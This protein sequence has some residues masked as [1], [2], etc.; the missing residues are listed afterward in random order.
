MDVAISPYWIIP[1][2]LLYFYLTDTYAN[3]KSSKKYPIAGGLSVLVPRVVQN[4]IFT[5]KAS[6]LCRKS[7]QKFK[8]HAVQFIRTD[9]N[10]VVLPY[11]VLDELS[12]LP[13]THAGPS[14][15][16]ENEL[17]GKYTSISLI[18]D[19]RL[20]FS[21]V[22]RRLTPKIPALAPILEKAATAAFTKYF[23]KAEDWT[24]ITPFDVF[25]EVAARVNATALVGPAFC[26]DPKWL[27]IG[28]K[29]TEH[30]ME[31]MIMLRMVPRLIQPTVAL[32]L[33]SY[34]KGRRCVKQA[35]ELLS[36]KIEEL[37]KANDSG[38]WDPMNSKEDADT[39]VM[40]WLAG[41]VKGNERTP[42]SV[43]HVQILLAF[44]SIH[45]TL[46]RLTNALYDIMAA[47]PSLLAELRAE[48]ESV[49]VDAKGWHD[50]PY[51]RLYKLD[52]LLRES[53]RTSPTILLGMKRYFK[54]PYTFRNGIHVPEGTY[55]TMFVSEIEHDLEYVP[56]PDK[57]DAFRAYREKQALGFTNPA[58]RD[59]DFAA[60]TRS[61][62]GF[63]YGRS[64]CPGRFFA[65]LEIKMIMVKLLT[66]YDFAFR[67]G[68]GRP[69]M[70]ALLDFLIV[71][72][73]VKILAKR[74][75]GHSAP[76]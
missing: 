54:K 51:D 74:R 15:G 3:W 61:N 25:G 43:V 29:Y 71:S 16:T 1:A 33:P 31:T 28:L 12:S 19:S 4:F 36:P 8:H 52:S 65:S 10:V 59:L 55:T 69:K 53:Q 48:I 58:S 50:M 7:Y 41:S 66:E 6:Q 40:S 44:A 27:H 11:E 67:P 34:W 64:A 75:E 76:F 35:R 49:A 73:T 24:E 72:P 14:E 26:D 39:N 13:V 60:A 37:L 5:I 38:S 68:E 30:L 2:V 46:T 32:F 22:Q 57:F 56:N 9:G 70:F 20:H 23:P 62:L 17:M 63:G 47:D 42:A 45:T 21:I 18:L